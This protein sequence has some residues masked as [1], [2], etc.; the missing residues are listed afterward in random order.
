M[1]KFTIKLDVTKLNKDK[2]RTYNRKDGTKVIEASIDVV[3][4]DADKHKVIVKGDGT[5]VQGDGWRLEKV[6]FLAET[7]TKE[8][9]A[10]MADS[11]FV[12]DVTEFK[13]TGESQ[14]DKKVDSSDGV[15]SPL[16]DDGNIP[17]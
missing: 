3:V 11:N 14:T 2:F 13:N 1:Q 7:P 15:D 8:E 16:E 6:G 5:P 10:N 17:F 4:M 12:G 9:K